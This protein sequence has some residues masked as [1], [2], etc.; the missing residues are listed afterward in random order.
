MDVTVQGQVTG[1][2][3]NASDPTHVTVTVQPFGMPEPI[4]WITFAVAAD[5]AA[6]YLPGTPATITVHVG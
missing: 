4:P 3:Q 2:Q 5:Q 1:L 6:A